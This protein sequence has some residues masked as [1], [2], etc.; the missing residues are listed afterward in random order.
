[1]LRSAPVALA[2]LFAVA[3]FH[4]TLLPAQYRADRAV[5][6]STLGRAAGGRRPT[7]T[8]LT[9]SPAPYGQPDSVRRAHSLGRHLLIGLGAGAAAGLAIGT[10]SRH[11]S[12]DCTDCMT[13]ASAIPAFG[14]V[15]GGA[16]GTMVGWLVY[17]ARS[18]GPRGAPAPR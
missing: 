14:V 16:V 13:P 18:S 10:Y 7:P 17:L 8:R 1:M 12:S 11:H 15:V 5:A 2:L 6:A 9:F 4:P 3:A